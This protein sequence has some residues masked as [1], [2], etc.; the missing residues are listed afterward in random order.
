MHADAA[1]FECNQV[2]AEYDQSARGGKQDSREGL[3]VP[4]MKEAPGGRALELGRNERFSFRDGG[5]RLHRIEHRTN[6]VDH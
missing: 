4:A 3:E 1:I 6:G 2:D 5:L